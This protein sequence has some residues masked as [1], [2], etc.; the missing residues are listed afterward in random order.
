[1]QI[2][3]AFLLVGLGG[4]LYG[5]HTHICQKREHNAFQN[6]Y[7]QAQKE[8]KIR[9]DAVA[10]MQAQMRPIV[11]VGIEEKGS[12]IKE[13]FPPDFIDKMHSNGRATARLK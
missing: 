7:M 5:L 11:P 9:Q 3:I 8:Y 2:C 10:Q 1:M 13:V 4:G 12:P 6:G